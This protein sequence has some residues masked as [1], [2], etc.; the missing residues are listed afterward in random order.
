MKSTRI[1]RNIVLAKFAYNVCTDFVE[2]FVVTV[3]ALNNEMN[4]LILRKS[5]KYERFPSWGRKRP[6]ELTYFCWIRIKV[7]EKCIADMFTHQF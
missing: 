2:Y 1:I 5:Q 4:P 7:V 3:N 6:G